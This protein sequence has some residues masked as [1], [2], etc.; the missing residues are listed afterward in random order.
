METAGNTVSEIVPPNPRQEVH[1]EAKPLSRASPT[2]PID[3]IS[4]A[5]ISVSGPFRSAAVDGELL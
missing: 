4:P 3:G 5:S 2:V 1:H